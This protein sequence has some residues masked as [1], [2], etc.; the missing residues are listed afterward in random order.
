M[1]KVWVAAITVA[2]AAGVAGAWG[3]RDFARHATAAETPAPAPAASGIPVTAGKVVAQDVPVFLNGIGTV[4]AYNMVTI[5]SR[6][7]GQIVGV[8]FTEG[9][10]V[11]AGD[12]L[13]QIDPRPYQAIL[14]QTEANKAKDEAQLAS[15][16]LD[17]QRYS[18]LV[19]PGYQ[20]RQSYDQQKAT[21][22]QLGAAIKADQAQID[23]AQLNINYCDIRAPVDGR[24]GARLVDQGNMVHA[25]DT[26]GL[27]TIAQLKPI[28]VSFTMAQT[29]LDTIR[30][31]QAKGPLVVRAYPSAGGE[32]LAEGALTLIDNA[33]DQATGTIRLKAS[34]ANQDERL[35]PGEFV[36]LRL[37]LDTRK[38]VPTVP[39]QTV[40]VGPTGNY[41]YLISD[42]DKA[43]RR[44]VEVASVQDGI[45]VVT[46]GLS[47]G[48]RV[49]VDGQYR[50]VEGAR[51]KIDQVEGKPAG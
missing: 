7:D 18:A 41:V 49:V 40:Q 21:V 11:K 42:D 5:K 51:V 38:K 6:V 31:H 16:Q 48:D 4:Q 20:T 14:E 19:G 45:A 27:V 17:L 44:P 9:Q 2:A 35:W 12:R 10:E 13:F 25:T 1:R 3:V 37:I 43:V 28:F 23:A 26:A 29:S 50:L 32:Q 33:I 47:P 15:A 8:N 22:A 36:S 24:L 30:Q 34:F 46:K 39:S